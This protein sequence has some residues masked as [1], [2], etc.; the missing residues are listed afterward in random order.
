MTSRSW[1]NRQNKHLEP[2]AEDLEWLINQPVVCD[3][4]LIRLLAEARERVHRLGIVLPS[5]STMGLGGEVRTEPEPVTKD[6]FIRRL[7]SLGVKVSRENYL[8]LVAP[9][10]DPDHLDAELEASL[11]PELRV[12]DKGDE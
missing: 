6:P 8:N 11:P 3:Q 1:R 5:T 10:V 12:Q 7:E 2:S 4:D 9:G